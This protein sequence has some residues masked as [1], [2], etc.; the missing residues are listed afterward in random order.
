MNGDLRVT[1]AD[2]GT[3]VPAGDKERIFERFQQSR[4]DHA[5]NITGNPQ[6]TGLGL[7]I[8]RQIVEYFGGRIWTEDRPGGGAAFIFT[9]PVARARRT[10][11]GTITG[12][13]EAAE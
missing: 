12:S 8:C 11:D 5:G 4:T 13:V 3:G 1:V 9:V 10:G 7:P 6:G 2:N